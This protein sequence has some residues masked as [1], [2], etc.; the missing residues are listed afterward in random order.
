[1][2][3]PINPKKSSQSKSTGRY[4]MPAKEFFDESSEEDSDIENDRK[5]IERAS[6]KIQNFKGQRI[7]AQ[8][9]ESMEKII[10]KQILKR[11]KKWENKEERLIRLSL[12]I[13]SIRNL[14]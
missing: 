7:N 12:H 13:L 1:M 14:F 6:R 2:R 4:S 10:Q 11:L 8:E 5:I 9:F 3:M